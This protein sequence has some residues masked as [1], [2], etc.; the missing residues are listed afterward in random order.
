MLFTVFLQTFKIA[1]YVSIFNCKNCANMLVLQFNCFSSSDISKFQFQLFYNQEY[2]LSSNFQ[3][4]YKYGH[5]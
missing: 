2:F 5:Y 1:Q 3:L 4:F